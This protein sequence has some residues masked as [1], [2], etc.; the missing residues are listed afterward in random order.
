MIYMYAYVCVYIYIY[1][2]IYVVRLGLARQP[3]GWP[4]SPDADREVALPR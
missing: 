3:T 2:Y 1:I 4:K